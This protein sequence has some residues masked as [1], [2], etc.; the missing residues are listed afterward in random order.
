MPMY[1]R[2]SSFPELEHLQPEARRRL[3][4]QTVPLGLWL[5]V[6]A[7]AV[8]TGLVP[9]IFVASFLVGFDFQPQTVA[10]ITGI[11]FVCLASLGYGFWITD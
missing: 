10:T 3:I 7:R 2:I 11:V 6:G 8:A 9:T 4:R 1:W 5:L